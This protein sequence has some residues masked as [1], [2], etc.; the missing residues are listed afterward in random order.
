MKRVIETKFYTFNQNNSGGSF[1]YDEEVGIGEY[2]IIEAINADDANSRAEDIGLY[3]NGCEDGYDC[4]CCGDRWSMVWGGE[5][6]EVPMIYG[7]PVEEVE[8]SGY[9]NQAYVHYIDETFKRVELK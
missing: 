3:F 6:D 8:K 5:G 1:V 7:Q 4:E 9:R 2:V